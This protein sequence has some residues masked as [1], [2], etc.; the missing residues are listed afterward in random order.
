MMAKPSSPQLLMHVILLGWT[1]HTSIFPFY[2]L[3][4]LIKEEKDLQKI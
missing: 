4:K 3:A 1:K 2:L